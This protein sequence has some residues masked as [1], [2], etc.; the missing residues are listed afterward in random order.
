MN[1]NLIEELKSLDFNDIGR[2]PLL[3]RAAFVGLF[4]A[5]AVG[6]GFYFLIYENQMPRL[7]RAQMEEKE[8]RVSF[9]QKQRKAEL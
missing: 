8:L 1:F 9:E 7:E 5:V 6:A 4:F 2:W 3:F